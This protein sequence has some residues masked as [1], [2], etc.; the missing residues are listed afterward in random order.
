MM[1]LHRDSIK[2]KKTSRRVLNRGST[3]EIATNSSNGN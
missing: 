1:E 2:I 3:L